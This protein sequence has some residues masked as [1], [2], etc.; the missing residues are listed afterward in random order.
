M[1]ENSIDLHL[2]S[3]LDV[4]ERLRMQSGKTAHLQVY[5][6]RSPDKKPIYF[7]SVYKICIFQ[8]I[9]HFEICFQIF[10]FPSRLEEHT[11]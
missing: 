8:N 2:K 1:L 7:I 10:F 11:K 5:I 6:S 3:S 4:Y 9:N